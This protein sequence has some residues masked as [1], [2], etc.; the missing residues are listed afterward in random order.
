VRR[1]RI[2]LEEGAI[3]GT[4]EIARR[5]EGGVE[6]IAFAHVQVPVGGSSRG[7]ADARIDLSPSDHR[8]PVAAILASEPKAYWLGPHDRNGSGWTL[9]LRAHRIGSRVVWRASTEGRDPRALKLSRRAPQQDVIEEAGWREV[10]LPGPLRGGRFHGAFVV[11]QEWVE[12]PSLHGLGCESPAALRMTGRGLAEFHARARLRNGVGVMDGPSHP[13]RS[14]DGE[15]QDVEAHLDSALRVFPGVE[16]GIRAAVARLRGDVSS[17]AAGDRARQA[18]LHGDL[19]DKQI[20][21]ESDRI[22]LIDLDRASSGDPAV[23]L[24]N[25]AAHLVLRA[26]Q[27]GDSTDTAWGRVRELVG[28]YGQVQAI[29]P[30]EVALLCRAALLRLALV[31]L[32]RMDSISLHPRL[33]VEER[34]ASEVI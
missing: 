17:R 16:E 33:L 26:L 3:R 1:G 24:G 23:D 20:L 22:V 32:F 5:S 15:L 14:L 6:E 31:Y 21:V 34:R 12:A 8:L 27:R 7:L 9:D 10:R 28:A 19:H 11:V 4:Y 2:D 13:I 18:T 25:L 29:P 30:A